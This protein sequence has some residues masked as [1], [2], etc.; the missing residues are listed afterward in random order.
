MNFASAI[1][2]Y[3]GTR[4]RILDGGGGGRIVAGRRWSNSFERI[5]GN[6]A[7]RQ[8]FSRLAARRAI[9][10]TSGDPR[11]I[12]DLRYNLRR[13]FNGVYRDF[14]CI[15]FRPETGADRVR[16][17]VVVVVVVVLP[18]NFTPTP[19]NFKTSVR[20]TFSSE[21]VNAAGYRARARLI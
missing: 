16:P 17:I 11:L 13:D 15:S 4:E 5:L 2:R 3:R 19:F 8:S 18:T 6:R 1:S 14:I 7:P 21:N 20:F 9:T 10:R 12:N